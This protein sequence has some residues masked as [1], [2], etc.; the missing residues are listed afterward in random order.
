MFVKTLTHHQFSYVV[1]FPVRYDLTVSFCFVFSLQHFKNLTSHKALPSRFEIK[2]FCRQLKF[3]PLLL[4]V[5]GRNHR[6]HFE[7]FSSLF[8][9]S[10]KF[11]SSPFQQNINEGDVDSREQTSSSKSSIKWMIVTKNV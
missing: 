4:G 11:S 3:I 2:L 7:L 8:F 5:Y 1:S 10:F 6:H 9:C